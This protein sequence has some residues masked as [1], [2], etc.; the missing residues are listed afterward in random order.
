MITED[1]IVELGVAFDRSFDAISD[2]RN[3][4]ILELFGSY[5]E[6]IF[7]QIIH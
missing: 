7:V 6:V 2:V 5:L 1:V 4:D 3:N